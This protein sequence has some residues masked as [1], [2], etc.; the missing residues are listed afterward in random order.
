MTHNAVGCMSEAFAGLLRDLNAAAAEFHADIRALFSIFGGMHRRFHLFD[1]LRV[2]V[3]AG[4]C[5]DG[6]D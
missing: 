4:V 3:V 5:I 6:E 2:A 1:V